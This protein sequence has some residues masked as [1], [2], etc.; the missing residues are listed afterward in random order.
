MG[1]HFLS[2]II[3]I[4]WDFLY[5]FQFDMY[6]TSFDDVTQSHLYMGETATGRASISSINT[7]GMVRVAVSMGK[8]VSVAVGTLSIELSVGM[9]IAVSML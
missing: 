7:G 3:F 6:P 5:E 9:A 4:S 2:I 8:S 1:V